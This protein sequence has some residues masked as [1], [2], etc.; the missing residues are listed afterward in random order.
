MKTKVQILELSHDDIVELLSTACY[1]SYVFTFTYDRDKYVGDCD[2]KANDCAEDV[3]A[4]ILFA[5]GDI[6][7]IDRYAEDAD[8]HYGNLT[9]HYD[10]GEMIYSVNY[11][12]IIRGL[13]AA[14]NY[15]TSW[16]RKCFNSFLNYEEGD[17]DQLR[18]ETLLQVIVFGEHIYG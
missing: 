5:G 13:N 1:G 10:D 12:D 3:A 15:E 7:I 9:A 4:K 18:A 6:C 2:F 17:F 11:G 14:A 16:V 8:E